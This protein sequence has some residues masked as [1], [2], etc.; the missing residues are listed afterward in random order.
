M[1]STKL[2]D[3]DFASRMLTAEPDEIVRMLGETAYADSLTE[4]GS[5]S[6]IE[7]S[8]L[9]EL[10]KTYDMLEKICPEPELMRLFRIRY[11]FDNLKAILKSNI[12]GIPY[13]DSVTDLGTYDAEKLSTALTEK[14]YRFI[15][16]HL[17]DAAL[18]AMAEY[19]Q[20]GR[21][22]AI[23]CSCDRSM[24]C[25]VM[26]RVRKHRNKTVTALFREYTNLTNI[27]T[28]LRIAEVTTD[29]SVFERFF[30]AGGDYTKDFFIHHMGEQLGLFLDHL[31]KTRYERDIVSHGLEMWPEDKAF[32]RLDIA[33][34]DF[35][36]R[37]FWNMRLELFGI[38]P[39]IYYLLRKTAEVELIRTIIKC[40]L[41]GMSRPQIEAHSRYAYV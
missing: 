21:L 7:T 16:E 6:E 36:L 14:K 18:E 19:Q 27:K 34:D 10:G 13:Q 1:L 37:R 9:R 23:S 40:K 17:K 12:T 33:C 2:L 39:L 25:Y 28:F 11:D 20:L 30:I 24:W 4:I 32:W 38:A 26:Q 35:V 29:S 8:L 41:I 3:R 15:P 22:D 5:P 31:A